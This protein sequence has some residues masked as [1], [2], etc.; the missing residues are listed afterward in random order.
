MSPAIARG[1]YFPSYIPSLD[2]ILGG[3]IQIGSTI[4]VLS[5]PGAGGSELLHASSL[6]YYQHKKQNDSPKTGTEDPGKIYYMSPT[7][8]KEMFLRR[9]SE[10]FRQD[11]FEAAETFDQY[12]RYVD[13]GEHF[14]AR[15][16]VPQNWYS[17][18]S[19]SI[20]DLPSR[21]DNYGGMTILLEILEAIPKKSLIMIDAFTPI[22]PYYMRNQGDWTEL[23]AIMRGL[24]RV[25]KLWGST[26]VILLAAGI[27]PK[28]KE[29]EMIECF[30]GAFRFFWQKNTAQT[31]QR[32][33]YVEKF[34][35]LLP[36]LD[37]RD[38]VT[39]NINISNAGF[40]I[41][42]LRVVS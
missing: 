10:Q 42:N 25:A 12:V 37:P 32:Q 33:M 22:V 4:V 8:S 9:M 7:M 16:M 31:R 27:L 14:F 38:V 29:I 21:S 35:G 15:T 2:K 6:A 5:E 36:T 3:G 19:S 11:L 30:D 20:Q 41:T 23:I 24:T 1:V 40:E 13:L 39:F 34:S 26:I 28:D 17:P 18:D